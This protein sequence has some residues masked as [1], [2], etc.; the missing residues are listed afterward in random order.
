MSKKNGTK[1]RAEFE[2]VSKAYEDMRK[3]ADA[4]TAQA[5]ELRLNFGERVINGEASLEKLAEELRKVEDERDGAIATVEAYA[6]KYQAAEDAYNAACRE[7]IEAAKVE[8]SSIRARG[9][10]E[11]ASVYKMVDALDEQLTEARQAISDASN[12]SGVQKNE[13]IMRISKEKRKAADIR[14]AADALQKALA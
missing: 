2:Q 8:C 14:R 5:A 11:M 6:S 10:R 1:A 4:L 7:R 9:A 3:R 13:M 12:L